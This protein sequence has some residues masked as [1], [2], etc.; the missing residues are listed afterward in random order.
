MKS[1]T[2]YLVGGDEHP[3]MWNEPRSVTTDPGGSTA[4]PDFVRRATEPSLSRTYFL[5]QPDKRRKWVDPGPKYGAGCK[6]IKQ[7][8]WPK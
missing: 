4:K 8:T 1:D 3:D 7:A 5:A 6:N 2:R